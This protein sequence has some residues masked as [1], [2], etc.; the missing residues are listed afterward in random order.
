MNDMSGSFSDAMPLPCLP[1]GKSRLAPPRAFSEATALVE[2][3]LNQLRA[4]ETALE[5]QLGEL[6]NYMRPKN[7]PMAESPAS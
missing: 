2:D 5:R 6:R 1:A 3:A 4:A 7:Q